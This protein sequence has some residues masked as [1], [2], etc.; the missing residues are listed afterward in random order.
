MHLFACQQR[1]LSSGNSLNSSVH[2]RNNWQSH[3]SMERVSHAHHAAGV[4]HLFLIGCNGMHKYNN[5]DH[6]MLT[7][8]TVVDGMVAAHVDKAAL[9]SM[10]TEQDYHEKK[11]RSIL[12]IL[13]RR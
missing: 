13:L 12:K 4:K 11:K 5:Q 7:T 10:N 2:H 6:N 1:V 8:M 3:T 9:W